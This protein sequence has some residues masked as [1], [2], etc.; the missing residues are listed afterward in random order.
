M[1]FCFWLKG[2]QGVS[3]L[4]LCCFPLYHHR[5][6]PIVLWAIISFSCALEWCDVDAAS[7]SATAI[8]PFTVFIL[9]VAQVLFS[10]GLLLLYAYSSRDYCVF[11]FVID[12]FPS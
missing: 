5:F 11:S 4:M 6:S 7:V 10:L 8:V 3:L 9:A 2:W 1:L 12:K